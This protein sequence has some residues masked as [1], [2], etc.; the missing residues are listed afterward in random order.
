MCSAD[1]VEAID[2]PCRCDRGELDCSTP[3]PPP[4]A[5]VVDD[6][7]ADDAGLDEDTDAGPGDANADTDAGEEVKESADAGSDELGP[8][9]KPVDDTPPTGSGVRFDDDEDA[10]LEAP[11]AVGTWTPVIEEPTEPVPERRGIGVRK[12]ELRPRAQTGCAATGTPDTF[13]FA[14]LALTLCVLARRRLS[15]CPV[16]GSGAAR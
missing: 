13:A 14:W 15:S 2:L 11:D 5:G 9:E 6:A 12:V 8:E 3:P 7:G 16:A 10:P 4:D 1:L